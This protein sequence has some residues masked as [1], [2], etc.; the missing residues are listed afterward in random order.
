[1]KTNFLL[2]CVLFKKFRRYTIIVTLLGGVISS[3][4]YAESG[5]M[6]S[7]EPGMLYGYPDLIVTINGGTGTLGRTGLLRYATTDCS[8]TSSFQHL[9]G[10]TFP[11]VS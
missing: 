3:F 7:I 5:V 6:H 1:M 11:Y 2:N 10:T 8:E 9:S 4:A